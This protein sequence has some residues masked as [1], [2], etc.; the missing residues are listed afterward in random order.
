MATTE[1]EPPQSTGLR[2][3]G[4]GWTYVMTEEDRAAFE[5]GRKDFAEGRC[6]DHDEFMAE[7]DQW[8]AE[9]RKSN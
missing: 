9:R 1:L 5:Q 7:L 3:G 2:R 6:M 4:A 8:F